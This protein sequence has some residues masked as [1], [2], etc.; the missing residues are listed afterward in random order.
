MCSYTQ[1][2]EEAAAKAAKRS[3]AAQEREQ[4][5]LVSLMYDL[6]LEMHRSCVYSLARSIARA[7]ALSLALSLTLSLSLSL[8][9]YLHAWLGLD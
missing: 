3:L 2:K 9:L 1:R 7:R 6:G 5:M 4:K 8:S